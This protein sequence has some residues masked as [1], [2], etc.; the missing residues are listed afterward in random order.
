MNIRDLLNRHVQYIADSK[1][2][3][4]KSEKK[5][6]TWFSGVLR[7]VPFSQ[8]QIAIHEKLVNELETVLQGPRTV[9]Q[10]KQAKH[11]HKVE[12]KPV[13]T[14]R[15]LDVEM[16]K[17]PIEKA[18]NQSCELLET[19]LYEMGKNSRGPRVRVSGAHGTIRHQE[20][21]YSSL[22]AF[23]KRVEKG[24]GTMSHVL[25]FKTRR[26]A[27]SVR[28]ATKLVIDSQ[29]IVPTEFSINRNGSLPGDDPRDN[30]LP[31]FKI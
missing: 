30:D 10:S 21:D 4:A 27:D 31:T 26:H 24:Y 23:M 15:W 13:S 12:H 16:L 25:L 11:E 6:K 17:E 8:K 2:R 7:H 9:T 18:F 29:V 1:L 22:P 3:N 5:Q 19:D 28:L 14:S 20:L